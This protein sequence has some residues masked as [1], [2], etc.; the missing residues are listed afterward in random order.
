MVVLPPS[1]EQR[2]TEFNLFPFPLKI[3]VEEDSNEC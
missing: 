2:E 1:E 3:I